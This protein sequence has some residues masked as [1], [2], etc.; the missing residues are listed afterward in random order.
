MCTFLGFMG[1]L[2]CVQA[3]EGVVVIGGT[4]NDR[5]NSAGDSLLVATA[6]DKGIIKS[7]I[8]SVCL[9]VCITT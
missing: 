5:S 9:L 3:V 6:G 7:S 2:S 4:E 1:N 8:M